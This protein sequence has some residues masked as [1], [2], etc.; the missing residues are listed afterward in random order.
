MSTDPAAANRSA[1]IPVIVDV[2]RVWSATENNTRNRIYISSGKYI[3]LTITES[4]GTF[5]A[6]RTSVSISDIPDALAGKADLDPA[7][8]F[9]ESSQIAPLEGRQTGVNTTDGNFRS[10]AS[11]LLFPGARTIAANFKNGPRRIGNTDGRCHFGQY[12]RDDSGI[13]Q[14]QPCIPL[15][16][17]AP[18]VVTGIEPDTYYS[19]AGTYDGTRSSS[20]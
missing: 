13:C 14:R 11:A 10:A 19:V 8:G 2:N 5:S 6:T 1:S 7:T 9:V 16:G 3:A 17:C 15:Q 12:L 4:G 20:I 18:R